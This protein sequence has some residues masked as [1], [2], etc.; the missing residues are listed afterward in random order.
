MAEE[1]RLR[2]VAVAVYAPA[3]LFGLAE[4]SMLPVVALSAIDRGATTSVAALISA[5]IGIGSLVTNIPAGVLATRVGE[6]KSMLLAAA[7]SVA[8]LVL[9]LLDLGT[10]SWPLVVYGAGVLLIGAASAVYS[11]ARQSY[12]TESVPLH[13]RAR[14]LS[15]LGGTMRVGVFVGPFLGAAAMQVWGPPGAYYLS[16]V[17]V[18]AAGAVVYRVPDL[19]TTAEVRAA[20]ASI[21]TWG[22]VKQQWRVYATL[23]AGILLLSGIRQTR[24]TVVP[25]WAAHLGLSPTASSVIYGFAGAIDALVFYP[26]GKVMDRYGRR[27]V[28]VPCAFM[29]GVSFVLMPLTHGALLLSVVAMVMGFG[30]GIGSGIIMTLGADVSPSIGRPT[31]IGI[32]NELADVGSGLGPLL[33]AAVTALAGLGPGIVVSGF[34]GFGAAAAL[35]TWIPRTVRRVRRVPAT[36]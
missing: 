31:H 11:L 14:A 33:L 2:S 36:E 20:A 12:L 17:A 13:M 8:G 7:V 29:L 22:M 21:T 25:L 18:L 1:F 32:W 9:C 4:G 16:L 23:G 6:R 10:G 5:L 34:V 15:T 26:A 3:T 28:A 19:E 30:N 27:W 24:Q 35:W